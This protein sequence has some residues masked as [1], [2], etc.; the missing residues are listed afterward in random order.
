MLSLNTM[1]GPRVTG[2]TRSENSTA[3][4]CGGGKEEGK[5]DAER[6]PS[7]GFFHF[8]F[9]TPF[10]SDRFVTTKCLGHHKPLLKIIRKLSTCRY[11][12]NIFMA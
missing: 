9:V 2:C 6:G 5:G 1:Q 12:Y 4:C 3:Q 10:R 7:F 8:C 11:I